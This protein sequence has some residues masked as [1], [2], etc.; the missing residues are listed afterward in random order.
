MHPTT[1]MQPSL[2][3]LNAAIDLIRAAPK[4]AGTIELIARRPAVGTREIIDHARFSLELGLVG[5]GWHR[6]PNIKTG[7][8]PNIDQ[9]ITLMGSRAI[10]AIA[11]DRDGWLGAGDQLF[12][13]LDLSEANCPPG[14]L[15]EVGT[16]VLRVS[17]HPHRGCAKFTKRYGSDVTKWVNSDVGRALNLRGVNAQVI[18]A[19]EAHRGDT[20]RKR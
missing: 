4:D 7:G 10:S 16:A 14:T 12:V 15:L 17:A 2:D 19:G 1:T 6:R 9:Q 5:D 8:P 20:V 11:P 3:D 18:T 13:D